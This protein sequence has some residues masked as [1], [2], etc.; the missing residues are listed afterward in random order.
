[1]IVFNRGKV[2]FY[3]EWSVRRL[4]LLGVELR[5]VRFSRAEKSCDAGRKSSTV[6]Y[7]SIIPNLQLELHMKGVDVPRF[8]G[9]SRVLQ[10]L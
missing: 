1:M 9:Q 2:F 10:F 3:N 7:S 6:Q 8:N 4:Y 5:P